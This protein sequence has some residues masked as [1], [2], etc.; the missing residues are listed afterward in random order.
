MPPNISITLSDQKLHFTLSNANVSIANAL[1]RTALTDVKTPVFLEKDMIFITNTSRLHNEILKQRLASIPIHVNDLDI[2]LEN[3]SVEIIKNNEGGSIEYVTTGDFKIKNI[4]N[5]K[6]L[7]EKE[8]QRIFPPNPITKDFILFA[9]LRPKITKDVPGEKIDIR[10]KISISSAK[11]NGMYNVLSTM[12]YGNTVDP[13]LQD[14]AWKKYLKQL[15]KLEI[16]PEQLQL[17][18]INWEN[19]RGKRY[20]MENSFD[21]IVETLGNYSNEEIIKKSCE[22][23]MEKL[24]LIIKNSEQFIYKESETNMSN[25][26]DIILKNEDYTI[27]KVIEGILYD[28][29]FNNSELISYVGFSKKH[30]HDSD[31]II[32]IAFN[33]ETTPD[34]IFPL[35]SECC[36]KGIEIFKHIRSSF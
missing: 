16:E 21:F 28:D 36:L 23:L 33:K 13:V 2:P 14:Q 26:Y 5:D 27:G 22:I 3:Y 32:R 11:E 24:N 35:I 1:R 25:C 34:K 31:S 10:A 9:R 12:S 18:K 6:Y 19:H 29:Y 30:P 17:E 15:E 8:V 20:F 4:K 7:T